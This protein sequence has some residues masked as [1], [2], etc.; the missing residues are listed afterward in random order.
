MA[1]AGARP[2]RIVVSNVQDCAV[3]RCCSPCGNMPPTHSCLQPQ[4][5]ALPTVYE[6]VSGRAQ[7]VA[8]A[9]AKAARVVRRCAVLC[10]VSCQAAAR[11]PGVC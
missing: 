11:G 7:G 1:L 2:L 8:A 9:E 5:N 6:L 10:C 4:I 3:S